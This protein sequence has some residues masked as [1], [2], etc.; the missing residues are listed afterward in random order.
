MEHR[1]GVELPPFAP[2]L[3]QSLRSLGYSLHSALA[4]LVDNSIA[5]GASTVGI[6]FNSAGAPRIVVLDNGSGMYE[7]DLVA[8]MRFGSADPR[9]TRG[10]SDLG[11]FGLGMKTASL[12]QCR[13]F[14]VVS[15]RGGA[16]AAARWDVDE[17]ERR[18]SWWLERPGLDEVPADVRGLLQRQGHGTAVIWETLDRLANG[19]RSDAPS[20]LDVAM[21]D[22]AD[23]LAIVFHR[24]L[25]GQMRGPFDIRLNGRPLPRI[26][27]FL[28][29]HA[30]GQSLHAETFPLEGSLVSV[31]PF[32][33]PFPSRLGEAE[34]AR[35]GG[36]EGLKTGHG[37]YI[38]RGGRLVVPGGWFRIVPSDQLARLARVRVD[39]PVALDHIWRV[40]IRKAAAE[41]PTA[42]RPHL[43]R[44]V[45]EVTQRSRRVYS[46]KGT[47]RISAEN[48]PLWQRQDG[49]DGAARWMVNRQHPVVA[50]A[51]HP[52]PEA[53]DVARLVRL[54]EATLPLHD[55][56]LHISNDLP[57]AEPQPFDPVELEATLLRLLEAFKDNPDMLKAIRD[58]LPTMEPFSRDPDLAREMAERLV[59]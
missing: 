12:S 33:L 45:G 7:G 53:G 20:T 40:D 24:F 22:A 17:S 6:D 8:A 2:F 58:R 14:T 10:V 25:A 50:T 23:H 56:H 54:L 15:G 38:Y 44:I 46:F 16:F 51:L 11:R 47:S 39:V 55:I 4:D 29:G 3:L 59:Q 5:A 19:G 9:A 28:E 34:L 37:F 27:P 1:S 57:V 13:R 41:P 52:H 31:S 30:R 21:V 36:R 48:V 35:A 26:D 18:N 32:V 49:R 42:L 43:R